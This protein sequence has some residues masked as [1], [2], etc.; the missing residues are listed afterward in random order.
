MTL[1]RGASLDTLSLRA[2]LLARMRSWFAERGVLEVETASLSAAATPDPALVSLGATGRSFSGFLHTSPEFMM[3]RLV[4][5][6]AGDIYQLCRVYR[7]G[8]LGR[9]HEPEFVLLEWY[10]IGFDEHALMNDVEALLG[11]LLG[12]LRVR[13]P[14]VRIAYDCALEAVL[15]LTSRSDTQALARSLRERGIDVPEA[16]PHD[17]VLD[18]AD[19]TA[20]SAG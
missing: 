18:L 5:D 4:A 8:E 12:P 15:G 11:E 14:A 10:R 1:Q 3:K 2:E 19:G 16:T 6:G 20:V 13:A 9:W 7:D 17:G